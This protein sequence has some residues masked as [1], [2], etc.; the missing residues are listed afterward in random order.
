MTTIK[1]WKR[2]KRI[3]KNEIKELMNVNKL[4]KNV[5][6]NLFISF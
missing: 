3:K 5:T 2:M 6:I 1:R 4:M